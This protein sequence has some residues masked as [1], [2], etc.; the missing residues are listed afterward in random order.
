M[1]ALEDSAEEDREAFEASIIAEVAEA[2]A[3]AELL[4][5]VRKRKIEDEIDAR[6]AALEDSAEDD[7]EV[8]EAS[9]I[10]EEAEAKASAVRASTQKS[11]SKNRGT[12]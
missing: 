10:A 4:S 1:A 3:K 6:M 9:R 7:R 2:K 11:A 12:V 8:F 5:Q